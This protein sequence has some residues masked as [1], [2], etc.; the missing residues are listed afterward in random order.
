MLLTIINFLALLPKNMKAKLKPP[1]SLVSMEPRKKNKIA[2]SFGFNPIGGGGGAEYATGLPSFEED[3]SDLVP[4]LQGSLAALDAA[5]TNPSPAGYGF[6]PNFNNITGYSADIYFKGTSVFFGYQ[7]GVTYEIR[8]DVVG[9]Y[10]GARY[11]TA[12]N[13]YKGHIRGD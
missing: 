6:D 8:Y 5:L 3:I 10:A 1:Y 4:I 11:V 13:T 7:L 12:K 9:V 2:V